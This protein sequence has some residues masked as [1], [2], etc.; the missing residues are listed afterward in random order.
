MPA[1][2]GLIQNKKIHGIASATGTST[3]HIRLTI[4]RVSTIH[5]YVP[6]GVE[7]KSG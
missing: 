2:K 4:A 7:K 5:N 6:I 3:L 1:M